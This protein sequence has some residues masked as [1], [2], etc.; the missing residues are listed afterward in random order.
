MYFTNTARGTFARIAVNADGLEF[1]DVEL[2]AS[3][4]MATT[5]DD[6]DDFALNTAGVAYVAQPTNSI[7]KIQPGGQQTIVAERGDIHGP[8]SI[9]IGWNETLYVTTVVGQLMASRKVVK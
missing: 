9:R 1:G 3:L 2:I 8:T 7:A 5:G 6:W 4:D